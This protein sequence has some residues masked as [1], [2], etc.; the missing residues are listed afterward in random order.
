MVQ[1]HLCIASAPAS[2]S[3]CTSS[4]TAASRPGSTAELTARMRAG[5]PSHSACTSAPASTR[6]RAQSTWPAHSSSSSSSDITCLPVCQH[7]TARTT[8]ATP[9]SGRCQDFCSCCQCISPMT[10]A[11]CVHKTCFCCAVAPGWRQAH[12][13]CWQHGVTTALTTLHTTIH[14]RHLPRP[15]H[16]HHSHPLSPPSTPPPP[17]LTPLTTTTLTTTSPHHPPQHPHHHHHSPRR[18][19]TCRGVHSF[20]SLPWM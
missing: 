7:T 10:E 6:Q 5:Q 9:Q 13:T 12:P 16:H 2:S 20:W 11:Y 8:C 15:P 18:M 1:G 3:S 19:A 14:T 17:P 4:S